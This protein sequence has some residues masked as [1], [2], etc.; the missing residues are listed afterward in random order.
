MTKSKKGLETKKI[1][2]VEKVAIF[3]GSGS[4]HLTGTG[5]DR[6]R[7]SGDSTWPAFYRALSTISFYSPQELAQVCQLGENQNHNYRAFKVWYFK[8]KYFF[9]HCYRKLISGKNLEGHELSMLQALPDFRKSLAHELK[10][11]Y[12]FNCIELRVDDLQRLFSFIPSLGQIFEHANV[13]TNWDRS[14]HRQYAKLTPSATETFPLH[15]LHGSFLNPDSL[16]LPLDHLFEDA[17]MKQGI[18]DRIANNPEN[19]A[20]LEKF[21]ALF[22]STSTIDELRR[23]HLRMMKVLAK[24]DL[25]I[26]WGLAFND[27]DL[28]LMSLTS[29]CLDDF[30]QAGKWPK[31]IIADISEVNRNQ[32]AA[33][34]QLRRENRFDFD[35]A[36]PNSLEIFSMRNI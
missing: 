4:V 30:R 17:I 35:P 5:M 2:G 11:A 29:A 22:R 33:L 31:F 24:V 28:E 23:S 25:V 10:T 15:E 1:S 12:D 14:I 13:T 3:S 16:Y 34:F 6:Y 19:N 26:V 20:S 18:D 9:Q 32:V 8:Q 27:D 36:K 21:S 7:T